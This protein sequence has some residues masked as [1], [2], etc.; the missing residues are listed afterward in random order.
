MRSTKTLVTCVITVLLACGVVTAAGGSTSGPSGWT[1]TALTPDSTYTGFKSESAQLAQTDP[2]LLNRSDSTP[3]NVVIKYDLDG[4]ASYAGG[5]AGLAATSPLVTGLALNDNK[6]AVAAYDKH[7]NKV[8]D[9]ISDAVQ[10]AVPSTKIGQT[11]TTAYG[12]VSAQ[13][14]ANKIDD[15]L[16]VDGV[17][18]VQKDSL[19]QPLDDNTDF[20]G[21]TAVWPSLGG[22]STAGSNVIVGVLDTGVW[23][24][25]PMLSPAGVASP[26]TGSPPWGCEFGDGTDV[27]HL[28]PT[29]ACNHKLI[30]AY[31]FTDTYMAVVG[32]TPGEFCNNAT[33]I[34]SARDSEGHGTHTMTTA[35]GDCVSSAPLYGIDRGPVCGIAPGAHVI[36]Y[37]VCLAQGC[38]SSDSVAAVQQAILDGVD[39]I[40]FSISGGAN[41]YTDPVELAFLDAFNAGISVNASAGN[42]GPGA[43]TTDHGGPWVTTV[44]A[45][46]GP[47]VLHLDAAPDRRRRRHVR[48]A[49]ASRSRPGSRRRPPVVLAQNLPGE[50]DLC[51]RRSSPRAPRPARSSS[52]SAAAPR[53]RAVARSTRASTSRGAARPG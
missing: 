49:P 34:C 3:V 47:R 39:V 12:G 38:F 48:R 22:S 51:G 19:E 45:S 20:I 50:D 9:Q 43:G 40:N 42:A 13:V 16:K 46:T 27:A 6:T 24:E 35:A 8:A 30:G 53:R 28:G 29:F 37:R 21:A 52:A 44:G 2:S 17:A 26:T 41:P 31:A 4:T 7:A 33:G 23:P 36:E 5:V 11:F 14:P 10:S 18:A 25:H 32:A 15:L 1:A